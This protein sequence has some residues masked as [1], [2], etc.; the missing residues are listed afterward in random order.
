[1][2]GCAITDN[3]KREQIM[4]QVWEPNDGLLFLGVGYATRKLAGVAKPNVIISRDGDLITIRTESTFKN[5]VITFKIGEE[6]DETTAD[7]RKV[8]VSPVLSL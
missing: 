4:K 8:K 5:T 7:D 2:V 1:M 3:S 6:F